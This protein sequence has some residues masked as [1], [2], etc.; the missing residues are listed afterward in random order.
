MPKDARDDV[1]E[2]AEE[3]R[4]NRSGPRWVWMMSDDPTMRAADD[5]GETDVGC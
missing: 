4:S 1:P 3:G 2:D 5:D